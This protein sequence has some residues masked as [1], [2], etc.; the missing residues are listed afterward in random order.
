MWKPTP[1]GFSQS[2]CLFRLW[3]SVF[4]DSRS[5]SRRKMESPHP[6]KSLLQLQLASDSSA[7]V[8]LPYI[9]ASLTPDDFLPS[10]HLSNW[11]TR[12][13]SLLYSKE[14]GG[15][16]AGLCL[17]QK[18]SILSKSTMAEFSQSWLGVALPILS[19]C[20]LHSC[21]HILRLNKYASKREMNHCLR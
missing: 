5:W 19:V 16:W 1:F 11:T 4:E 7:V 15:R 12:I 14:S 2:S 17:A 3:L 18:T 13:N 20:T 10:P 21:F 9:L 6:L 8:N